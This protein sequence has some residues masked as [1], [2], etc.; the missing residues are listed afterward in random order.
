MRKITQDKGV[1]GL[2]HP[3]QDQ[4]LLLYY[5]GRHAFGDSPLELSHQAV[6]RLSHQETA[7][8]GAH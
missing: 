2:A 8:V 6:K 5:F 1:D 7:R 4:L 3:R